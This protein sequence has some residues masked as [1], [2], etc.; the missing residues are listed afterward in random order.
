MQNWILL[1]GTRGFSK[2]G[3]KVV[4][5]RL[6]QKVEILNIYLVY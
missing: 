3:A 6:V 1:M 2:V 5:S 4:V